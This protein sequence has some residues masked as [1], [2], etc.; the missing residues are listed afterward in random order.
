[1]GGDTHVMTPLPGTVYGP[2]DWE[3]ADLTSWLSEN[4]PEA[5]RSQRPTGNLTHDESEGN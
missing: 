3:E 4:A 2:D 1:M 5:Y